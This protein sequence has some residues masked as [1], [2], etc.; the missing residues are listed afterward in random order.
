MGHR[1]ERFDVTCRSEFSNRLAPDQ[2]KLENPL[3]L[4][5]AGYRYFIF[6]YPPFSKSFVDTTTLDLSKYRMDLIVGGE[7]MSE[8]LR[9]HLF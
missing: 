5:G 2:K 8:P 4:F 1:H 9:T 6:G 7:G 3:E